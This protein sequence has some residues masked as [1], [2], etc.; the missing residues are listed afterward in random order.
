[1]VKKP[2]VNGGETRDACLIPGLGRFP[3]EGNANPLQYYC[4]ENSMDRGVWQAAVH[5]VGKSWTYRMS[6]YANVYYLLACILSPFFLLGDF[7]YW[8]GILYISLILTPLQ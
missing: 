1:M 4:L 7:F 5:G 8:C 6:T 2:P 3:G